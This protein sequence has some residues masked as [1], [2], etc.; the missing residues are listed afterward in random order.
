MAAGRQRKDKRAKA[1]AL[2]ALIAARDAY[3]SLSEGS[4][5]GELPVCL[6]GDGGRGSVAD[7]L[8]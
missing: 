8:L 5:G 6:L 1:K 3:E 2:K 7:Q 4:S